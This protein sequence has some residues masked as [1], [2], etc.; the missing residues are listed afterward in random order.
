M[1]SQTQAKGG[2]YQILSTPSPLEVSFRIL[3]DAVQFR[4]DD[5]PYENQP[6]ITCEYPKIKP[7]FLTDYYPDYVYTY[8]S[9][10]SDGLWLYFARPKTDAERDTPFKTFYTTRNYPW[11]AV[12][13]DLYVVKSSIPITA[14]GQEAPRFLPR[15]RYRPAVSVDSICRVDQ[16]L[17]AIEWP[18]TTFIHQQPVPTDVN[19]SYLGV[20]V[21][22][23]RCLHPTIVF[24]ETDPASTVVYGIGVQE[25]PAGRNPTRMT[26]P[27]TNFTDWAPFVISDRQEPTN[28]V[29]LRERV[30]IYP[31]QLPDTVIS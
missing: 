5:L 11:P 7:K 18:K 19:G 30:T 27:A 13:E 31:P 1:A 3:A 6:F 28:G 12:L 9:R 8:A 26:F 16:Y 29:W 2:A 10:D 4:P 22:F 21:D 23:P 15:A 14:S 20:S 24:P 17:S 25:V